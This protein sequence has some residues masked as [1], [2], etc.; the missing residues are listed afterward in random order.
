MAKSR[1]GSR[2]NGILELEDLQ[3]HSDTVALLKA[4]RGR[5]REKKIYLDGN[6]TLYQKEGFTYH[7]EHAY[8]DKSAMILYITAPFTGYM[9]RN[10]V[11]GASLEYHTESKEAFATAVDAVVYTA[12]K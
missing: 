3:Y 2:E 5:Y 11:R 9:Q 7:T 4:D 6:V 12:E 1:Y 10:I 8:Y